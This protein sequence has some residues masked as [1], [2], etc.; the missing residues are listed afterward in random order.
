[1]SE[2]G[3]KSER[4]RA[5]VFET[6]LGLFRQRGFEQTT[7]REIAKG[8]GLSL[9]A[10]YHHFPSKDAL[11]LEYYRWMQSEH[12]ARVER[13]S[14]ETPDESLQGRLARLLESKLELLSEDRRLLSA[15]FRGLV[16]PEG[17][18]SVFSEETAAIRQRSQAQFEALF[19]D[20]EVE[21]EL[22]ALLGRATWGAHL[23][24]FLYFVHDRSQDHSRTRRLASEL[25]TLTATLVP[26]LGHPFAQPVT[27][28]A[29]GLAKELGLLEEITDSA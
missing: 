19:A 18:L 28:R 5:K 23:A 13:A 27:A 20:L 24:L 21:P 2:R 6:A 15:L 14:R 11:V 16:D 4:T 10:A 1:V 17:S 8:V 29:L 22:K 26:F 12:E 3:K 9:G 25:S 7:M